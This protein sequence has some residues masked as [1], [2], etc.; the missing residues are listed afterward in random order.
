MHLAHDDVLMQHKSGSLAVH[1]QDG[2][3]AVGI[4]EHAG[5]SQEGGPF[6][7]EDDARLKQQ[8]L[9]QVEFWFSDS[10]LPYDEFM[11]KLHVAPGADH[12]VYLDIIAGFKRMRKYEQ[13]GR[14]WLANVLRSSKSLEVHRNGKYVRRIEPV[15][16]R[17]VEQWNRTAYI[18][19]FER[20]TLRADIEAFVEPFGPVLAVR[21]RRY[22]DAPWAKDK[23]P[24]PHEFKGSVWVEFP[25]ADEMKKFVA[26][27]P[28]PMW[29]EK[30]LVISTKEAYFAKK[31]ADT[32][33]FRVTTLDKMRKRNATDRFIASFYA[34]NT[35]SKSNQP[36]APAQQPQKREVY[37]DFMGQE[38]RA[39]RLGEGADLPEGAPKPGPDEW[40][41][42][43]KKDIQHVKGATLLVTAK[44]TKRGDG[45]VFNA[46]R[47]CLARIKI[48]PLPLPSITR[49]TI[50]M[51]KTTR[52][53]VFCFQTPVSDDTLARIRAE[54]HK[55][56]DCQLEWTRVSY[57]EEREVQ[58]KSANAMARGA[59]GGYKETNVDAAKE[60]SKPSK[61][62]KKT[63]RSATREK[64]KGPTKVQHQIEKMLANL[65]KLQEKMTGR[66]VTK[67]DMLSWTLERGS[68]S[69]EGK[70]KR[71][72]E[73]SEDSEEEV[74]ALMQ[75]SPSKRARVA[76][77]SDS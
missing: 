27:V 19:G 39:W 3:T 64:K 25:S 46:T 34:L 59:L 30:E 70:R 20:E 40:E 5:A 11:W 58:Y 17:A 65:C 77:S 61:K 66:P 22:E 29:K 21:M 50:M 72:D 67:E 31:L 48:V 54:V 45:N 10:N 76:G 74:E 7:K 73:D 2:A 43:R 24:F 69:A 9:R 37:I 35:D 33:T 18:G 41:F 28:K 71:P 57:K 44:E 68:V 49:E 12:W 47:D 14:D 53:A 52:T 23:W 26:T 6:T 4:V 60:K 13:Y 32:P 55:M 16:D 38:L 15:M 36:N 75:A 8:C 62:A 42:V 56:Y 1:E 51:D 63:L